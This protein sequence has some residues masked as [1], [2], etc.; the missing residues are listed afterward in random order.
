M[1]SEARGPGA[2]D[3][4]NKTIVTDEPILNVAV[5]VPL[6]QYFDYR[7]AAGGTMPAPGCRVSVP[8]GRRREVG[9]V[10]AT[11]GGS[12]L[13]ESRLRRAGAAIDETPLLS[14][15][16]L[17]LI[18]FTSDYYHHPV[19]EV[20][21][22][23]LPALL[24]K[25][26]TLY[27]ELQFV[28]LTDDGRSADPRELSRRAPRQAEILEALHEASGGELDADT[29]TGRVANWRRVAK[30]LEDKGL[31][32][33]ET[34][35]PESESA[36]DALQ[37]TPG[38]RLNDDQQSAVD[39]VRA[40][41]GF[42]P[43]VLDGITGSGKTEVYLRLI[44]DV[45]ARG[46]QAL[47]LVPEIGLTPQLVGRMRTRLG[48]EPAVLHS[49]LTDAE[50]LGA[51][52]RARAG[53]AGLVV[54]TRSAIFTP[55]PNLGLVVVDEEHDHS[56]KQQEGLRY[57]ARDL[58]IA[59]ANRRGIPIVLGSATPTLEMLRHCQE[60]RYTHLEL[61]ERA[62][63][64]LPPSM[65][66]IDFGRAPAEDGLGAPLIAAIERHLA[67]NGQVLLFLNRRG[68]APTLICAA[69]G[70]VAECRR[71]DARMTVH[72][73]ERRLRCH[74]CG[75][76]RPVDEHC[77]ECGGELRQLGAGTERLEDALVRRFPND[78]V[79]RIDSDSVQRKGA[80]DAALAKAERGDAKILVGTQMLSK[81]HHFPGL[82]LVAVINAD[83]GLFSTDFRADERMAQSII[84]V[85]GRAGREH[86]RGEVLIQT[87]FPQHPFWQR[88][89]DGG[90]AGLVR[91]MLAEREA[92]GWP[93]YSRLA[94]V[95]ASAHRREDAHVFLDAARKCAESEGKPGLA[96]LGPVDAIMPRR[97][98]R[99]RAQLLLQSTDRALLH[100]SL[101][102]LRD[103]LEGAPV[104]RRARWSIDVDPIE[105]L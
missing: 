93:P 71:C 34:R 30:A 98:G 47:V 17:W 66:V 59:R 72:A 92:T 23:A 40:S 67:S 95:R 100:H 82:T 102:H 74:H 96:I 29:L 94:L 54:G 101:A 44:A 16:D 45:V 88:L 37:A 32:V 25:G 99:Y 55:L 60:G 87:A 75:D 41:S 58:A 56:F 1:F 97:A 81:G 49:G 36:P 31:I 80:M 61:R 20:V 15:E 9:L 18:R 70:H 10:L 53:D 79:T 51:W 105:L 69:C 62:G 63:G 57:S 86:A 2:N 3:L 27:P 19:G 89:I 13:D 11:S 78:D 68:F 7:A 48:I 21:A 22:A 14:D 76:S 77:S 73:G 26:G 84:Q 104:A 33:R 83:Q 85:A 6:S 52:R 4:R 64:A 12:N 43:F 39:A 65:H 91:D 46:E 8:F 103:A 38:P 24:R 90:Y 35:R 5:N 28:A 50:R 42:A